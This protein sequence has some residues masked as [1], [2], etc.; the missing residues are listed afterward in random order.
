ML[1]NR[2]REKLLHAVT[3]FAEN[4]NKCGKIKLF[5]LLYFLDF[6]HYKL[7]GR[8]VTGMDYFAWQMGPVPVELYDEISSPQPDMAEMLLFKEIP[9]YQ[10][11]STM[12][13]VETKKDFD[14]SYFTKRELKI[15]NFLVNSYKNK[16]ADDM[17]EATHLEN[18]PWH[19]IYIVENKKREKIPYELAFR[20]QEIEEMKRIA[21]D[22]LEVIKKLS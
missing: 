6:E 20:K 3:F 22:H 18:L 1:I 14:C 5:K 10:G 16:L 12:L 7:T 9:V 4:V 13:K 8:S 19:Q 11:Q 21:K 17:I 2:D 15:M